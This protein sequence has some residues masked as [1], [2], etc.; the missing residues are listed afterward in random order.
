MIILYT[1][2][3]YLRKHNAKCHMF[4][5]EVNNLYVIKS[6]TKVSN[7]KKSHNNN[8]TYGIKYRPRESF[9]GKSSIESIVHRYK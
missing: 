6:S 4:S 1:D 3:N 7:K 9:L 8:M 5:R 2:Y